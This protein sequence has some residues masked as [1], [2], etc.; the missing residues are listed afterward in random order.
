MLFIE[1]LVNIYSDSLKCLV[2]LNEKYDNSVVESFFKILKRKL[3]NQL[4]VF[5]RLELEKHL[6]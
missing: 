1:K 4:D 5:N 6:K 3:L 2:Y